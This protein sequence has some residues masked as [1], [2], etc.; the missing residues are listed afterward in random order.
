[1][2]KVSIYLA[3]FVLALA[4]VGTKAAFGVFSVDIRVAATN[5]DAEENVASGSVDLASS[6][7]ELVHDFSLAPDSLQMV[8]IR[9]TGVGLPSGAR[10][11]KAWVQFTADDV[12]NDYHIPPVSL[13]IEGE[14][15]PSPAEFASSERDVSSRARTTVSVVWDI[16]QWGAFYLASPDQQTSDISAIIQELIDQHGWEA[17]NAIVL[18]FRDNPDIPSGGT[19][20]AEA[21]DGDKAQAP[22]LHIE[23]TVPYAT[24]PNPVDGGIGG[25]APL[26]QWT[27]G[28]TAVYHDVYFGTNPDLGPADYMDRWPWAMYWHAPGLTPGATHYWRVDEVE[29]DGTTIHTGDLWSFTA[30]GF[31]AHSPDP[32]DGNKTALP[33]VVLSWRPGVNAATHDVYFGPSRVDVAAGTGGTFKR[34]QA[35]KTYAPEGLQNGTV[36]F[37][38]IDEVE[39]DGTTK[40]AGEVWGF[41]TLDDPALVGW[42]KLDERQGIVAFD[43]SG[44]GNHGTIGGNP[45][46]AAGAIDGALLLDGSDDYISIDGVA[47]HMTNNN[48]TVSAWIKTKQADEGTLFGSNSGS[49]SNLQFGVKSGNVWV[50]DGPETQFPPAVNNNQWH[51]VTYV[52]DGATAYIY[53]D[54]VLQGTDPAEDEPAADLRWSIGQEWDN[55]PSDEFE[56]TVDD[57][58]FYTR[59][60]SDEEVA[61]VFRGDVDL[62]HSPKPAD[63]STPD[64]ERATPLSWSPGEKATEH[65]V[66]FGTDELTVQAVDASD[67][68]GIYRS[69]Q[70]LTS[71]T[72]PEALAWGGGPYYWRID[73][74]NSDGTISKG[75]VWSF[76]V[77]N[78]LIVDDF[79]DYNDWPPNEIYTAW[80]DGYLN[81]ANGAQ[82]GYLTPPLVETVIVHGGGQSMP[83]SYGNTGGATYSEAERSFAVGQ[84]WTRH[85]IQ[86]L[87]LYFHGTSG[88][89]GQLYVKVNGSKV[90]YDGDAADIARPRW[91]QWNIDLASLGIDLQNVTTLGI[92]MDG[93]GASGTLYFDDIRLYRQSP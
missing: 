85:G 24:N 57:A 9:F 8:G 77:A 49:T 19:R 45:Q 61:R 47:D 60:L 15:S 14:L 62:A 20:E 82:A 83:L 90:L 78:Y 36:Y 31:A 55:S 21:F 69:R 41:R 86:T 64:V 92:G 71:Y 73:E 39:A 75:N 59:P 16:P 66:Y 40:H 63:G 89:T 87:V 7:L 37:W 4:L 5:D 50:D 79:E 81:P 53:I 23:Y 12:N 46:P 1:M 29:A 42:W 80:Q 56:G 84:D 30:V 76:T 3:S 35:S 54:G 10:I 88:N 93:D 25:S 38:R 27:A 18:M 13:I 22:L 68:T 6:D 2:S 48:F 51:M 34:N 17:G 44:Y 74:N 58:R 67:T 91:K 11:R 33:D 65:D 70:S 32:P 52:R 43:S 26:M 28:D 72:P